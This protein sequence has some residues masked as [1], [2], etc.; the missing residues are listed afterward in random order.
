MKTKLQRSDLFIYP[1]NIA[2]FDLF[3]FFI[4]QHC[5]R[6]LKLQF[7]ILTA[8]GNISADIIHKTYDKFGFV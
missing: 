4:G 7:Y 8:K 5:F 2:F 3:N 1:I 6:I